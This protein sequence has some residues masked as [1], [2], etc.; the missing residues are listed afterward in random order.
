ML[1]THTIKEGGTPL[2]A[3]AAPLL[4]VPAMVVLLAVTVPRHEAPMEPEQLAPA[5]TM[6]DSACPNASPERG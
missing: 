2:W 3:L 6:E 5:T 1:N 4:G